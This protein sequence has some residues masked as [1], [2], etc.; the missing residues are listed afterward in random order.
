MP[1]FVILAACWDGSVHASPWS[2]L[3]A[4]CKHK[5]ELA[6]CLC[7]QW[8]QNEIPVDKK[9]YIFEV[10]MAGFVPLVFRRRGFRRKW[11]RFRGIEARAE[12]DCAG[13][14]FFLNN[15]T[16]Q[17]PSRSVINLTQSIP[18]KQSLLGT[19]QP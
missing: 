18:S 10:M 3:Y 14:L 16:Q 7:I 17:T 12:I 1:V 15:K 4:G 13:S 6:H 9:Q 5:Q 2:D 19:C 8:W 11:W